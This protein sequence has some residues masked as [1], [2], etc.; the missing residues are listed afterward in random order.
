MWLK[1]GAQWMTQM[2][3]GMR[4]AFSV[5]MRLSELS[6]VTEPTKHDSWTENELRFCRGDFASYM[7]AA[8]FEPQELVQFLEFCASKIHGT[9]NRKS[10]PR[11]KECLATK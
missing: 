10:I 6:S 1:G 8:K 5:G 4:R 7:P 2:G 11:L 9:Q 3:F